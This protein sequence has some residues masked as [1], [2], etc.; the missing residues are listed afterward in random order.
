MNY[1]HM[2][3]LKLMFTDIQ[4]RHLFMASALRNRTYEQSGYAHTYVHMC[5]HRY[6]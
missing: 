6:I 5:V 1:V 4:P 2:Y 3:L